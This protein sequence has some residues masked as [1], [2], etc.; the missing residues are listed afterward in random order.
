MVNEIKVVYPT[1]KTLDFSVYYDNGGTMTAREV[2]Q[3]LTEQ[4]AGSGLYKGTPAAIEAGDIVIIE[5]GSD[6]V[7]AAEYRAGVPRLE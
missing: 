5:E 7:A 4:P 3:A 6:T 1:G 2:D